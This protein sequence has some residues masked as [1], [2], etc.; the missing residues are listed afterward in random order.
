M[1]I[2]LYTMPNCPHCVRAKDALD[3][4]G[5]TYTAVS[6]PDKSKRHA[7]YDG[8]ADDMAMYPQNVRRTMPKLR[9]GD[10]WVPC[11]DDIV[12]MCL[13]GVL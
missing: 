12:D 7:F 9:A 11:A 6:I 2:T 1:T 5:V 3:D 8:I 10:T 4:H 13:M